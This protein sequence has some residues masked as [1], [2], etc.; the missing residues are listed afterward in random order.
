MVFGMPKEAIELGAADKVLPLSR[1]AAEIMQAGAE[2]AT[3]R[4]S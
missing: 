2:R 3:A 1:V 4:A